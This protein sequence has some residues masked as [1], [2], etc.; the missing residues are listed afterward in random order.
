MG[1]EVI[2]GRDI[3]TALGCADA[4]L[5]VAEMLITSI[6]DIEEGTQP[7]AVQPAFGDAVAAAANLAFAIE[8]Y[9]KAILDVSHV[10]VPRGRDGHNLGK[11]YTKLPNHF[12]VRIE[13]FYD[14]VRKRNPLRQSITF[15]LGGP[16]QPEWSDVRGESQELEALLTRSS[17]LFSSWRYIHEFSLSDKD[18]YQFHRFE[19][20]GL[21]AAC[22]AM[23]DTVNASRN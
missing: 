2:H 22:R 8:L 10:E 21:L 19:Y 1:E 12:K 9:I 6:I 18:G 7:G 4:F 15:A 23:R 14:E 5:R 16:K 17:D 13:H 11:L 20:S 3:N